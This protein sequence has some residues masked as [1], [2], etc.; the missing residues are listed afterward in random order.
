[1][2]RDV[3]SIG[4]HYPRDCEAWS[5]GNFLLYTFLGL[6]MAHE[7]IRIV[8]EYQSGNVEAINQYVEALEI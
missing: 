4:N 8:K 6:N 5:F 7:R 3:A 1:L 2:T